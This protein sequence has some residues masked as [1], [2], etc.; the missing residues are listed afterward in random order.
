MKNGF[1]KINRAMLNWGWY[2]EPATKLVFLHLILTCAY[3]DYSFRGIELKAGQTVLTIRELSQKLGL[4]TK[5]IRTALERLAKGQ[6]IDKQ[7]AKGLTLVTLTNWAKY[8]IKD[9]EGANKGQTKGKQRANDANHSLL[10]LKEDIII[11]NSE[12][13][14]YD[15]IQNEMLASHQWQDLVIMTLRSS[16]NVT[17]THARIVDLIKQFILECK[18]KGTMHNLQGAR[19]HFINWLGKKSEKGDKAPELGSIPVDRTIPNSR[20]SR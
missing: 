19:N 20:Y 13:P 9:E 4:S 7:R 12:L 18:A 1:V 11:K 8:Q 17:Y 14:N 3:N 16:Q 5:Q 15:E 10:Y 6:E 2:D